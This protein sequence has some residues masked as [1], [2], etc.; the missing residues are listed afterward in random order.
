MFHSNL[1]N[2]HCLDHY[3]YPIEQFRHSC[4]MAELVTAVDCYAQRNAIHYK[5]K[6][7]EFDP[8]WGSIFLQLAFLAYLPLKHLLDPR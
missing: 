3:I 4:P 2:H 1:C 7:P 6:G 8:Q 5:S